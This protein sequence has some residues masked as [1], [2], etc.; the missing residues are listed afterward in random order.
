M[1]RLILLFGAALAVGACNN[2]SKTE[3]AA[4]TKDTAATTSATPATEPA[5]VL[6]SATMMKNWMEYA[7][8]GE[9]H[10]MMA[11]WNGTWDGEVTMWET[12]DAPPQKSTT[13]TVNKMI[14]DGRYQI[15]THSGNMM[16]MPFEGQ[17]TVGYDNGKKQFVSSW[18]DNMGTGIMYLSGP[19]DAASKSMTL[20]GK[21]VDPSSG[22]GHEVTMRE[23]F[24]VIDDNAH[25]MEMYCPGKDGKEFKTMEIKFTRKK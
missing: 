2:A 4:A 8:P 11:S 9:V 20:T 14:M 19:W 10:K 22:N 25:V 23:V 15:S 1:K 24:R 3:E 12:A 18:I 13:K 7:T 21:M 6:D 5:P 17:A 16:G